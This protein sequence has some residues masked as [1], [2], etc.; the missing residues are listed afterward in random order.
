L[1]GRT[2]IRPRAADREYGIEPA[3]IIWIFG[4][5]RTGSTWL[6][7][8]MGEM[9]GHSVWNEPLVGALFGNLYYQRGEHRA[10]RPGKHYIFGEDYRE[11]W[12]ES[13]RAFV[14]REASGRFRKTVGPGS[15]L[16]I[17]EPNGAAGA[18]LLMEALPESRMVL[19]VRDPRDVVASALDANREGGWRHERKSRGQ[20]KPN[21]RAEQDPDAVLRWR[22][23]TY[24]ESVKRAR[25]AYEAHKG[26]KVLVRY[27]ELRADT[28][29]TIK[30]IYSALEI[31]VEEKKLAQA[32]EK[33]SWENISEE[34]KGSGKILRKATPG[35]WR[36]DLTPKQ[37][38]QVERITA[39]LLE[40]YYSSKSIF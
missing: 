32:V 7:R 11:S 33:H 16:V 23:R 36:E 34:E 22:A 35:G 38:K 28:L 8:M 9:P 21:T 40:E 17:K 26:R 15:F 31:P 29:K 10:G 25:L 13:I 14:L 37:I 2:D 24:R 39:P 30:R 18:P 3:N 6:S 5:A 20:R 19:L 27:E 4:G 1:A 12:L